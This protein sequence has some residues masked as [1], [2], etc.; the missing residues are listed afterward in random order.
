MIRRFMNEALAAGTLG[1]PNIVESTDMGFTKTDMPYIVFEYLEGTLARRRD[2]SRRGLPLARALR[3]A[4]QI[5]SALDAAHEAGIIHRDLKADN[6]FLTDKDDAPDHVKVLDFGISRFLDRERRDRA[7]ATLTGT[8]E[9]MAPEQIRAPRP[10]DRARRHLRARRV[11]YEMLAGHV[12]FAPAAEREVP[13]RHRHRARAARAHPSRRPPS[14]ARADAPPGLIEM[15]I[16]KLLA[17]DAT[18]RY[19]SMKQVQRALEAFATVLPASH[20]HAALDVADHAQ[21]LSPDQLV[22]EVRQLGSRWTLENGML[23]LD[24]YHRELVRLAA[25]AARAAAMADVLAARPR[26]AIVSI[27]TCAS[28]SPTRRA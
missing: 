24:I 5:A 22:A 17:K 6:V 15:V 3:I 14:F 13:A 21:E 2:R 18:Q 28:R 9:Y 19:Q 20:P 27:R 4:Y 1:H 10:V 26:I 8:P 11:L 23:N 12:P 16:D 7:P 25:A